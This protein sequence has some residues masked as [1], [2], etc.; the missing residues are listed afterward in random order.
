MPAR[1]IQATAQ[2]VSSPPEKAMPMGVPGAGSWRWMRLMGCRYHIPHVGDVPNPR[3]R[4]SGKCQDARIAYAAARDRNGAKNTCTVCSSWWQ[5]IS[6]VF[7]AAFTT[8]V[9]KW[10]HLW[11]LKT[12]I[13]RMESAGTYCEYFVF[14]SAA[15]PCS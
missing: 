4:M 11:E 10:P 6:V 12:S 3:R 7:F 9:G 5:K 8:T 1:A 15:A 13:E 14:A 2:R